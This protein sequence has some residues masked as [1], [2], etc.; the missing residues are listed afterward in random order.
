MTLDMKCI[1]VEILK[2]GGT[3][4]NYTIYKNVLYVGVPVTREQN[5]CVEIVM[6]SLRPSYG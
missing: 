3:I 1:Y 5:P 6:C 2:N 4:T